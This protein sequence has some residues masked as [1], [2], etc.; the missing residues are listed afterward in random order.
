LD[1][2]AAISGPLLHGTG[3]GNIALLIDR[4]EEDRKVVETAA[5]VALRTSEDRDLDTDDV[6]DPTGTRSPWG[7]FQELPVR[8]GP[9][10][11]V[12]IKA[13]VLTKRDDAFL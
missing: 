1:R 13:F 7:G 12:V 8:L 9:I 11:F 2:A 10:L 4:I 5:L 3:E 6:T